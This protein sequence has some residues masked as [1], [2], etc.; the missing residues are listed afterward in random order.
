MLILTFTA[1][2][3]RNG[4][5]YYNA[6]EVTEM[7]DMEKVIK[8]LNCCTHT[9]GT[10]CPNCPYRQD[11]DCVEA[12]IA[13]ALALLKEQGEEIS[14]KTENFNRLVAKVGVMPKIVRCDDGMPDK[15]R[16]E[17]IESYIKI[18]N[19]DYK[20]SDNHG[21]LVRCKDCKHKV[22]TVDDYDYESKCPC[23]CS[24]DA[25]YSWVPDDDWFCPRGERRS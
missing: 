10:E 19:G 9:D 23:Y 12:L 2:T 20:W 21:E 15:K 11:N 14:I 4:Y 7:P 5:D 3:G 13:D 6:E 25:Y 17:F 22:D 1:N 18:G 16:V 8:G 24:G